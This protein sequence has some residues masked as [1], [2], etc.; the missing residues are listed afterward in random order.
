MVGK[1]ISEADFEAQATALREQII[2]QHQTTE[3][4]FGTRVLA[5]ADFTASGRSLESIENFIQGKVLPL[6]GN[7]HTLTTATAR[8]STFFRHEARQVAKQYLNCCPLSDALIF[9]QNGTTGAVHKFVSLLEGGYL[10][11]HAATA[12]SS[13]RD[14]CV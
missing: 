4:P 13:G 10:A 12:A 5:Y 11:R 3:T 9:C 7:V 2:G 14:S 6:Y 8:Q 1:M